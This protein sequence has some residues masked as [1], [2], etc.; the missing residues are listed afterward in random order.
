MKQVRFLSYLKSHTGVSIYQLKTKPKTV[1][2]A[3][4]EIA[5]KFPQIS[6]LILDEVPEVSFILGNKVLI[7]PQELNL[8][9]NDELIIG[10]IVGGG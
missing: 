1:N 2:D 5:S 4:E 8:S 9:L 3:L 6:E 7:T 10:P